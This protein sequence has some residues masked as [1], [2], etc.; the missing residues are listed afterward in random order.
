[1]KKSQNV[2]AFTL[3]E[4]IIV[5]GILAILLAIMIPSCGRAKERVECLASTYQIGVQGNVSLA[6]LVNKSGVNGAAEALVGSNNSP[7]KIDGIVG[8]DQ[9]YTEDVRLVDRSRL[10]LLTD[11]NMGGTY[12][13]ATLREL[14]SLSIGA[15]NRLPSDTIIVALGSYKIVPISNPAQA[16]SGDEKVYPNIVF[17]KTRSFKSLLFGPDKDWPEGTLFAVVKK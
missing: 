13:N 1:M 10:R 14:L 5:L 17:A 3:L 15:Y 2:R 6:E 12:R 9:L 11:P 8:D 7:I 4:L 16:T